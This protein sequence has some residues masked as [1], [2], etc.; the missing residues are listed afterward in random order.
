MGGGYLQ[1]H[2][3]L[4]ASKPV[5][6]SLSSVVIGALLNVRVGPSRSEVGVVYQEPKAVVQQAVCILVC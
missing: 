3:P 1:R 5:S 2:P 4:F 6:S